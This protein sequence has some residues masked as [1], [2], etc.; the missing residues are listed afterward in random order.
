MFCPDSAFCGLRKGGCSEGLGI[1]CIEQSPVP[2]KDKPKSSCW[3]LG[4]TGFRVYPRDLYW[5]TVRLCKD[6]NL[7]M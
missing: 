4:F 6:S 3:G 2:I 5:L 7:S 1:V